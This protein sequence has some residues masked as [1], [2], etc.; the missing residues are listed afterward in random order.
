MGDELTNQWL[1]LANKRVLLV[2]AGGFGSEIARALLDEGSQIY[3]VD[4]QTN[5]DLESSSLGKFGYES[6]ELTNQEDCL[7]IVEN[8]AEFLGG[9]DIFIYALGVNN[10]VSIDKITTEDYRR[11]H[12]INLELGLW[13]AQGVHHKMIGRGGKMVFFSSVSAFLA[14]PNH[15]AYAA[16]KGALNQLLRVMAIEWAKKGIHVNAVAPGYAVTPLTQNYLERDNHYAELVSRVPAGRLARIQDVVGP[17]LFL[18]SNRSDYVTGQTIIIDGGR[19]L[20]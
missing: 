1:G 12:L 18:S 20:D 8:A 15:G 19:T 4:K 10:R 16:S 13:L 11:I 6:R 17:V 3:I 7:A 9:L 14:H 2:G 5:L